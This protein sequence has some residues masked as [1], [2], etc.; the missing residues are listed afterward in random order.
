L[1]PETYFKFNQLIFSHSDLPETWIITTKR[2]NRKYIVC[3]LYLLYA[4][5]KQLQHR[6][7]LL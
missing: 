5:G 1:P 4:M 3:E 7:D 6:R 2:W